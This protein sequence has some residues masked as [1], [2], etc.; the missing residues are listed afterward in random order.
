[1]PTPREVEQ[2]VLEALD[3]LQ[4]MREG[5]RRGVASVHPENVQPVNW[6]SLKMYLDETNGVEEATFKLLRAAIRQATAIQ[7]AAECPAPSAS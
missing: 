4:G 5:F 6:S 2:T 7:E 3:R 1:M